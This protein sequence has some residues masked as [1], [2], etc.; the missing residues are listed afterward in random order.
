MC[1]VPREVA[2]KW[3]NPQT[4]EGSLYQRWNYWQRRKY[5]PK[6]TVSDCSGYSEENKRR[7]RLQNPGAVITLVKQP[8]LTDKKERVKWLKET[9]ATGIYRRGVIVIE[10]KNLRKEDEQLEIDNRRY[11]AELQQLEK[12]IKQAENN[13][14]A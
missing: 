13:A 4:A 5:D 3:Y 2:R 14:G 9:R 8:D 7:K 10:L 6:L 1:D 12:D 11:L